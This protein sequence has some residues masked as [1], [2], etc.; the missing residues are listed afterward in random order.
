MQWHLYQ[1]INHSS[2]PHHQQIWY[3]PSLPH[4]VICNLLWDQRCSQSGCNYI[5]PGYGLSLVDT[6]WNASSYRQPLEQEG[7][8]MTKIEILA[9]NLFNC[10][11]EVINAPPVPSISRC[12]HIVYRHKNV[13]E[14]QWSNFIYNCMS[15][16]LH[17][18]HCKDA[19]LDCSAPGGERCESLTWVDVIG[20]IHKSYNAH[21]PYPRMHHSEQ[22]CAHFCSEWCILGY[23]K[24]CIMGFV[25]SVYSQWDTVRN[26]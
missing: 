1:T 9:S 25:R 14:Y 20:L 10:R 18:V 21:V 5:N 24:Q 11:K 17:Y 7:N 19:L 15:T 26:H 6:L 23:M 4:Y 2:K 12:I 22:K 16:F 13:W 3:W 8:P